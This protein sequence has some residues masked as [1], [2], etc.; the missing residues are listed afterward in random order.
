MPSASAAQ[1]SDADFAPLLAGAKAGS[2]WELRRIYDWLS[3]PVGGYLRSQ[4]VPD[5]EAAANETFFRAFSRIGQFKGSV[6][7]FRSWVF[8]IAHNLVIDERRRAARRP[9][10]RPVQGTHELDRVADAA[11]ND[12]LM[13]IEL[14]AAV[15]MLGSLTNAQRDVIFLRV[16][17]GLTV[18]ET[19]DVM[20]RPPGAVKALQHRG[21]LALR[22]QLESEPRVTR[23]ADSTFEG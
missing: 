10:T 17:A 3:G 7:G 15:A 13:G 11:G 21:L 14:E 4:G 8:T 2:G 22:H 12:E 1:P 20:G 18:A 5:P 19:A 9:R 23:T 16:I 6:S